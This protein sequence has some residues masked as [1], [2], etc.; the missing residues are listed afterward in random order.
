[1]IAHDAG[2]A[3]H[4]PLLGLI[5]PKPLSDV[6]ST[7]TL[8]DPELATP[9]AEAGSGCGRRVTAEPASGCNLNAATLAS[10]DSTATSTNATVYAPPVRIARAPVSEAYDEA[11]TL[12]GLILLIIGAVV[13]VSEAHYPTHGIAGGLGVTVMAV[14]AVLAISGLGAGLL[15]GLAGGVVL[16]G[17]GAGAVALSLRPGLAVR[18]RRVRTGAEGMVGQIAVVRNW[19]DCAGDVAL[20]GALWRACRSSGMEDDEPCD[21]HAGDRVVVERL[22]GLTLSVRPAEEWELL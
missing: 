5:A 19:A 15:L 7:L 10:R 6:R 8:P 12:L 18:Q 14:G 4:P 16:A 11:M 20:G 22:S 9:A 1:M 13:A 21:L 2:H 3:K 17:A